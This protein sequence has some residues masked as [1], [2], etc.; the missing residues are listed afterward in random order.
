MLAVLC[1]TGFS[2]CGREEPKITLVALSPSPEETDEPAPLTGGWYGY[3]SAS[4]ASGDW[5]SMGGKY[6]DCCAEVRREE[7]GDILLLWDEDMSQENYLARL[8]LEET[9]GRYSC[10]GGDF[11]GVMLTPEDVCLKMSNREGPVLQ[12]IGQCEDSVTGSFSYSVSLRPWGDIWPESGRRPA[13][14]E[15]WYLPKIEAGTGMPDKIDGK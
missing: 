10:T 12:I 7:N 14:Y 5:K 9:E 6:F 3:W 15:N 1:L 13:Y 11:L 8:T 2:A 4:G